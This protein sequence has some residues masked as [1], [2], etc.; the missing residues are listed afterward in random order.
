MAHRT[1]STVTLKWNMLR[2][3]HRGGK[4]SNENRRHW[5]VPIKFHRNSIEQPNPIKFTLQVKSSELIPL[6]DFPSRN[7]TKLICNFKVLRSQLLKIIGLNFFE[8]N[9][10][11][12]LII[13]FFLELIRPWSCCFLRVSSKEFRYPNGHTWNNKRR[14]K[15]HDEKE[16]KKKKKTFCLFKHRNCLLKQ[17]PGNRENL[18]HFDVVGNFPIFS[19]CRPTKCS[20]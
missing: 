13:F 12:P 15:S 6:I 7:S 2:G 1:T 5:D 16:K 18:T 11:H 9:E 4:Y 10:R 19:T 14:R 20:D 17:L 3:G 8:L